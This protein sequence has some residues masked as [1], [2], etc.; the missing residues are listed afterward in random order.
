MSATY[1]A[2]A[3]ILK[4]LEGGYCEGLSCGTAASGETYRGIDRKQSGK[5][6]SG[7]SLIDAWKKSNGRPKNQSFFTGTA[8]QLIDNEVEKFWSAWWNKYGFAQLTNQH[9]AGML[10]AWSAQGQNR[11]LGDANRIAQSFGA[12]RISNSTL[13][14]EAAAA[15]NANVAAAYTTLRNRISKFYTDNRLQKIGK[16]RLAPFPTSISNRP[17]S[18]AAT[19]GPLSW[20][21]AM[22]GLNFLR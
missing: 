6:W 16:A 22:V 14:P 15:I 12:K 1:K 2:S 19:T 7:W 20:I 8:G 18:G 10:F 3:N 17:T 9:F 21:A 4:Q 13:T 11:A 5:N